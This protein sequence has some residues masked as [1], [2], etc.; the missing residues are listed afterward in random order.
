MSD[1]GQSIQSKQPTIVFLSLK[2]MQ[3]VSNVNTIQLNSMLF[4]LVENFVTNK[5][6]LLSID[7]LK[8]T[9]LISTLPFHHLHAYGAHIWFTFWLSLNFHMLNRIAI[10]IDLVSGR[11]SMGFSFYNFTDEMI[12][13]LGLGTIEKIQSRFYICLNQLFA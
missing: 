12:P 9:A 2:I 5:C 6:M 10:E 8:T 11:K 4:D 13:I 1:C 3:I 7:I